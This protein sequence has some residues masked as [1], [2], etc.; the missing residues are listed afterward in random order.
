MGRERPN[1]TD[2]GST[3]SIGW[4]SD[5]D[6]GAAS[7][8]RS[9]ARPLPCS[10]LVEP[11]SSW[12][13]SPASGLGPPGASRRRW[14]RRPASARRSPRRRR[15]RWRRRSPGPLPD[16]GRRVRARGFDRQAGGD[17]PRWA[18]RRLGRPR[19]Y[20]RPAPTEASTRLY[21]TRA[22]RG[23]LPS[24]DG[25][26]R[27]GASAAPS[28]AQGVPPRAREPRRRT[29]RRH[30]RGVGGRRRRRDGACQGR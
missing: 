12:P 30:R 15:R 27:N 20:G 13:P 8:A 29:N 25:G 9:G 18:H 28:A 11:C 2:A 5:G 14:R 24:V 3:V 19:R 7:T 23:P 21:Y 6:D 22:S 4:T 1:G 10:L 16:G 26:R 17:D